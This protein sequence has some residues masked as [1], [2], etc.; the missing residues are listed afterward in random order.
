MTDVA[1]FFTRFGETW[2]TGKVDVVDELMPADVAYQTVRVAERLGFTD[3]SDVLAEVAN[4]VTR[5]AARPGNPAAHRAP[6]L[7]AGSF[8]H[9]PAAIRH[10]DEHARPRPPGHGSRQR[11]A[12]GSTRLS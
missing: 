11:Q 5:D 2:V 8:P 6:Q 4:A 3:Y 12:H 7:A 1:E 10:G 9:P